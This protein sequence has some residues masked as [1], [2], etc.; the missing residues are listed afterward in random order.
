[1]YCNKCG[2]K[3]ENQGKFCPRCGTKIDIVV[4]N[5]SK[6][7]DMQKHKKQGRKNVILKVFIGIVLVVAISGGF[8]V[9][10]NLLDEKSRED[11][12][13]VVEVD[14]TERYKENAKKNEE[15][16][17]ENGEKIMK[18]E[19][20]IKIDAI[21]R[22]DKAA[23]EAKYTEA[24]EIIQQAVDEVGEDRELEDKYA[25]YEMNYIDFVVQKA[26][27]LIQEEKYEE[28]KNILRECSNEV[29]GNEKIEEKIEMIDF[30]KPVG[31]ESLHII[32]EKGMKRIEGVY[33]DSFEETY[34]GAFRFEYVGGV[35]GE[36]YA[37]F[38]LKGECS[39]FSGSIVA[40]QETGSDEKMIIQ[41]YVDNEL[42]YTSPQFG[43]TSDRIDFEVSTD[44][45]EQLMIKTGLVSGQSG[46]AHCSI[47][48][49]LLKKD[50]DKVVANL[51][52]GKEN[53][54]N[55]MEAGLEKLSLID[56]YYFD[57]R[58]GIFNDSFGN[59]YDNS[60]HFKYIGS[61]GKEK[62]AIFN[63]KGQCT[64]L[65]GSI[66]AC[67]ETGGIE[68]MVIMIYVDDELKYTSPHFT[69]TT[70]KI[71]FKVEISNGDNITIKPGLVSGDWGD[72]CCSLVNLKVIS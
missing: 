66:V 51:K 33:V 42:K 59:T 52:K 8:F 24:V 25:E 22:A 49:S 5:E 53:A 43:K 54:Y 15:V 71:D 63:V 57:Q 62:Y 46:Q 2:K 3:L 40:C 50:S 4:T 1:M 61:S 11:L 55:V 60:Y 68:Q 39:I 18:A 67:Q 58:E 10:L 48:N 12:Q 32:D 72:A 30:M 20:E 23:A 41:I 36:R 14:T 45:G 6:Y 19:E 65:E 34:D 29:P 7:E 28:S 16:L 13:N 31:L 44:G 64:A 70:G 56:S 21:E 47:V 37:I 35:E 38:N 9:V 17:S 26:D 69:K 27:E